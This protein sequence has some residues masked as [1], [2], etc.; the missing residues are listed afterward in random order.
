MD[1]WRELELFVQIA[2]KGSMSKAAEM[3]G[4][5]NGAASRHLS[6]LEKRLDARLIDRNTRSLRLTEIGQAFYGRCKNA[7]DDL[8]DAE[9]AVSAASSDPA[10]VLRV[11]GPLS[12]CMNELAPLMPAFMERYPKVV[13]QLTA[14]NRYRD[15]FE[16][17]IDIAIRTRRTEVD[18]NVTTRRLVSTGRSLAASPGYIARHGMPGRPE[19]LVFHRLLTYAYVTQRKL[20]LT[21]A[22]RT[23]KI[24]PRSAFEANDGQILRVVAM[25]GYGI[26]MQPNYIIH[27]DI[28]TG[29]LV[30]VLPDWQLAPLH[31]NLSY[32]SRSHLPAKS[33]AFIDFIVAHFQ[34]REKQSR[35]MGRPPSGNAKS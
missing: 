31:I 22:R 9:S 8:R 10:G 29:R 19:D 25:K 3:L 6:A 11:T 13:V 26:S 18:S 32:P 34:T 33:R 27:E 1:R 2:E 5:S 16:S 14:E 4:M 28:V 21:R 23:V 17:G 30:R 20:S 12:F 35:W 24:T 15:L 7:L